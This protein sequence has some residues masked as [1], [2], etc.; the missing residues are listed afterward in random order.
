ML[1]VQLF[2]ESKR[3]WGTPPKKNMEPE[4]LLKKRGNIDPNHQ[5]VGSS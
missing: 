2:D 4:N 5:F 1:E 3:F